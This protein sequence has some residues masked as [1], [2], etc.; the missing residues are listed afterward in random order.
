MSN[1]YLRAFVIGSSCLVFLPYFYAVSRFSPEK[2]NFDYVTYTF[3]APIGLGFMN[4]LS[5][6]F[7]KIF[8][9]SRKIR[10]LLTSVLA[11][12]FVLFM[13][14]MLSVYNYTMNEWINHAITLYVFYFFIVNFI[15][16]NLD[17]YV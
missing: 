2:F 9:F 12:T 17:K 8:H 13:V 15:L 14:Y 6:I 1:E 5:L 3:L 11:P 10:Y 7:A 4:L 16:Y